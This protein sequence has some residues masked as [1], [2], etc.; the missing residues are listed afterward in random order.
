MMSKP[1]AGDQFM[2]KFEGKN[3]KDINALYSRGANMLRENQIMYP[4]END[5]KIFIVHVTPRHED[6]IVIFL[7]N[8]AKCLADKS[9][10]VTVI[11]ATAIKKKYSGKIF[12]EAFSQKDVRDS[13]EGFTNVRLGK[14]LVQLKRQDYV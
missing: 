14:D 13:L 12:V 5:P 6:E 10:K 11:T 2:R 4:G 7:L 8:K 3:D 9:N 1:R